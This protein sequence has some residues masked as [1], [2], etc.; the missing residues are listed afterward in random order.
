MENA[1]QA[2][3]MA[4][5]VLIAIMVIS[6]GVYLFSSASRI[7]ESYETTMSATEIQKFNNQFEKYSKKPKYVRE[8]SLNKHHYINQIAEVPV[9]EQY[10]YSFCD[11]NTISDVVS[12][13]NLAYNIN[14][15]NQYEQDI[16]IQVSIEGLARVDS[17]DIR[18]SKPDYGINPS[19]QSYLQTSSVQN[20]LKNNGKKYNYCVYILDDVNNKKI[21]DSISISPSDVI[22]IEEL[23]LKCNNS[24][25][26]NRK[27][28][29]YEYGFAGET[30][31]NPKTGL[32]DRIKFTLESNSLYNQFK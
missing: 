30:I 7:A 12:A 1:S 5:G 24:A 18:G 11:Y 22:N 29:V 13:I 14:A 31:L 3:F 21:Y 28:R 32:I 20:E 2:L 8:I 15:N 26:N 9:A 19:I 6:I 17:L 10:K 25:L 16:G 4:A 23:L 27:E